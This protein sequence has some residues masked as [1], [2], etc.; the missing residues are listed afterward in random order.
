MSNINAGLDIDRPLDPPED[1]YALGGIS[2][3]DYE[4]ELPL[5]YDCSNEVQAHFLFKDIPMNVRRALFRAMD[6]L[7]M[8]HMTREVAG[9]DIVDA[10]S[11]FIGLIDGGRIHEILPDIY[12]EN[13]PEEN[14]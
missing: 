11:D 5:N 2:P 10:L 3:L 4:S 14:R 9:S 8:G 1:D 6:Q 12:D 13:D 7:A